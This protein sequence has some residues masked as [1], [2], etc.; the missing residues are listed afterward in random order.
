MTCPACRHW[1]SA[2]SIRCPHC[3][4]L[5][6]PARAAAT[7]RPVHLRILPSLRRSTV[8][9]SATRADPPQLGGLPMAESPTLPPPQ[10]A[11][12][13][14]VA[15]TAPDGA[16]PTRAP[17][18]GEIVGRVEGFVRDVPLPQ[19]PRLA[20]HA[21]LAM[22]GLVGLPAWLL[23]LLAVL[24]LFRLFRVRTGVW[25]AIWSRL[26]SG[27]RGERGRGRCDE[28][29]VVDAQER[30]TTIKVPGYL[31]GPVR[32]GDRVALRVRR[33]R[34]NALLRSGRNLSQEGQ[35][36]R[37]PRDPWPALLLLMWLWIGAVSAC[38][39][40]PFLLAG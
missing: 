30:A 10:L 27:P 5:L 38:F 15:A 21:A 7:P 23:L 32:D 1:C 37:P 34:G 16:L 36:L 22:V 17:R 4:V 9:E 24:A 14:P 40:L 3:Q 12:Q 11:Q 2:Q 35:P 19:G 13:E 39:A 31:V 28:F 29:T 33:G 6:G 18:A 26:F 20:R 8:Q 25:L